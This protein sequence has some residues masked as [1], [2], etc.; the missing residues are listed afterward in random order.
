M[1]Y[2]ARPVSSY[3]ELP[4]TCFQAPYLLLALFFFFFGFLG[5]HIWLFRAEAYRSSQARGRIRDVAA[6]LHH[7]H[8]YVGYEP[9]VQLTPQ[10]PILHRL[11]EARDW[12][13]IL[14]EI[15]VGF[16]TCWATTA[17]P[18]RYIFLELAHTQR[19]IMQKISLTISVV[20]LHIQTISH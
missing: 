20:C 14:M 17:T 12:T 16:V 1:Y 19:L 6:G 11:S 18:G 13:H 7:S 9:H 2:R 15:L 4:K 5:L 3:T 8:S 10:T